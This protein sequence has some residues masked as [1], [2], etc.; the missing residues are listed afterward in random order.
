LDFEIGICDCRECECISQYC[1]V[2][3]YLGV[4]SAA[5]D[6]VAAVAVGGLGRHFCM[7]IVAGL[8]L[9]NRNVWCF[10]NGAAGLNEG[11]VKRGR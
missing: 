11:L 4:G 6:G 10:W 9:R 7:G 1:V 8:R 2:Y 5:G 3:T